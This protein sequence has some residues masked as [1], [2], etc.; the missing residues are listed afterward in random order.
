M[1]RFL[2]FIIVFCML[3][4]SVN[5]FAVSLNYTDEDGRTI[6]L[7]DFI[8]TKGHWAHDQILKWADY[9]IIV[10]N[11][12]YFMPDNPIIRGDLAIVID[13]M[14]GLKNTTYNYF[15]DLYSSD[16]YR[17]SILKCVSEGYING[18]GNNQVN[19]RGN[20]TRE[21]VAVILCRIFKL[22]TSYSGSTGFK[23]DS[24]ISSWARSSVYAL[25]RLGYLNGTPDGKVNPK[26][27]ITRAEM[28]TLLNNFAD[29]YVPKKDNDNS[30]AN[31][32][33]N[34][35][36]NLVMSRNISLNNSTVG[37]DVYLT[38]SSSSLN[39]TNTSVR[40]RIVCFDRVNI[41]LDNS[42]VHQIY[43]FNGKSVITG[44]S[45]LVEEVYV[46]EYASE[47]TLDT[48]PN[49]LVLE[50]GVRVKVNGVM[51][52]NITNRTKTYNGESLRA[53]ISDEQGFVVGGP[54]ITTGQVTLTYD[55]TLILENVKVTEGDNEIREVGI[56]W[57]ESDKD[58]EPINPTYK[59]NDGRKRYTGAYYEPFTFELEDV[60]DYCTY[61]LY[62]RDRDDLYA[63]ST[64]FTIEAYTF[65]ITMDISEEDY[66]SKLKADVVFRGSNVPPVRSVQVIYA[67]DDLYEEEQSTVGLRKYTEQYAE[68]PTDDTR[69]LRYTGTVN[70]PTERIDGETVYIPP[71]AFGYI[72]TFGDGSI[73]NR[74]PI[75][76]DVV[77][78]NVDPV[79]TLISGL[80]TFG[81]NRITINDS[82]V[83]TNLVS[84][85]EVGM[86]YKESSSS[87]MSKPSGNTSG[88]IRVVGGRNLDVKETYIFDTNIPISDTSLNTFYV[89]Y[90]KTSNGY[91]YG[92]VSKVENN[93]LGEVGGPQIVSINNISVL[94]ENTVAVKLTVETENSLNITDNCILTCKKNGIDNL[95]LL[96]E[97]LS[98]LD[99]AR[100]ASDNS[101]VLYFTGLS[102]NTKY[103]LGIRLKDSLGLGSNLV[104]I[105][106]NTSNKINV[107]LSNKASAQNGD[108]TYSVNFPNNL[109]YGLYLE[110][111]SIVNDFNTV[112][113]TST[114]SNGSTVYVPNTIDTTNSKVLL[115][116]TYS[117]QNGISKKE[118]K[119]NRILDLY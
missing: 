67:E 13:R 63:Y 19:P 16:Y 6:K 32:V 99:Y 81:N 102:E 116:C 26:S 42:S 46:C 69:Y 9:D 101:L 106:F 77:P 61:R 37:R 28:I 41:T 89:P 30:G 118:Y 112:I 62:V 54:K 40:G 52:E 11:N 84:V 55:N 111:H 66:P 65:S 119:F 72:I 18:V 58:E 115:V 8:D 43:L 73:I 68:N 64:P 80:V 86:A 3:F 44:I 85:E 50:P 33:S 29:T 70:S 92:E 110:G 79:K 34:I 105:S 60:E 74:F 17:E 7:T 93:W 25:N 51:Y 87:T 1:K 71:T 15:S 21:E 83:I 108:I 2:S 94:N 22:D 35:P 75:L 53:E 96:Y 31:F 12:G 76:T 38:Q 4:S 14:L 39:L 5:V 78:N 88:W 49:R 48:F 98:T 57:L 59:K 90:V 36:K 109:E 107:S 117:V 27:N 95:E 56:V 103:D 10:G 23:D 114:N 20:A 91:F 113:K 24:S 100:N 104:N 97:S 45:E 47:S 82:K